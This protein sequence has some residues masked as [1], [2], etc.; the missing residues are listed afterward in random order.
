MASSNEITSDDW[1]GLEQAIRGFEQAW[2]QGARPAIEDFLPGG[3]AARRAV[4]VELVH[5]D[6]ECRLKAGEAI[7]IE[8]Y[9]E[10]FPEL[11]QERDFLLSLV[12]A[13]IQLRRRAEPEVGTAEYAGRF[14]QI[15]D[16]LAELLPSEIGRASCRERV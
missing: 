7:R 6:L 14:P 5:A 1:A 11:T 9:L 10:R 15:K 16:Q 12:V 4:L 2:R 13:E 8:H 3:G